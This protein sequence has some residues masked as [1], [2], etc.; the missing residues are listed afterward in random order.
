RPELGRGGEEDVQAPTGALIARRRTSH[1]I[2]RPKCLSLDGRNYSGEALWAMPASECP[3]KGLPGRLFREITTSAKEVRRLGCCSLVI[4]YPAGGSPQPVGAAVSRQLN[5]GHE[6]AT[7]PGARR[8]CITGPSSTSTSRGLSRQ[9]SMSG[10]RR[11]R[12]GPHG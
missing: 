11:S 12:A 4:R 5:P 3:R 1:P 10:Y 7:P 6:L 9:P 2:R 8:A